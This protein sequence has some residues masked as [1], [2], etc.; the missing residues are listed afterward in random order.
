MRSEFDVIV[1][2]TVC[3]DLIWRVDQLAA[4]GSY[5]HILEERKL[6]GGEAANTAMALA[7]WGV[8]VALV[9][10]ALGDDDDGRV[11]RQMLAQEAE[12]VDTRSIQTLPAVQTPHCVCI[13]TPDG[14]RTMYGRGFSEMQCP[15]LT[16]ELARSARL[17]TMDPNA[18]EAGARACAI[19]AQAGMEIVAMDY[20]RLP[21]VNR[22]ASIVVTSHEHIGPDGSAEEYAVYA[23]NLRDTYGPTAIVTWG[24]NGCLVAEK[25]KTG[26]RA[27][28]VPAYVAP[29][30]VDTTGAGDIFRAGLI[31]GRLQAWEAQTTARFA[32]AAAALNCGAMGGWGGV[33]S[34]PEIY[35][36]Q[37]M[38]KTHPA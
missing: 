7:R 17:F 29:E 24:Q 15:V 30:V 8:R 14:H 10:T 33:R 6:I 27:V 19:A 37:R 2:G 9:G 5:E 38:A 28:H 13:A 20:T 26:E 32:S 36:F 31:Y 22:A 4:P 34:L 21:D 25:G 23:A 3:L 1:Y 11:L 16:P 12:D 18:Y 35:A